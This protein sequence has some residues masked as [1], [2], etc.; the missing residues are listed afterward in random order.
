MA[1]RLET[2][3][4]DVDYLEA[5]GFKGAERFSAKLRREVLEAFVR[6]LDTDEV[7]KSLVP[8][9]AE[10]LKQVMLVSH[11]AGRRR[12]YMD[13]GL[14]NLTMYPQYEETLAWAKKRARLTPEQL[15]AIEH[16]YTE[17]AA[18]I[19]VGFDASVQKRLANAVSKIVDQ[20]QHIQEGVSTLQR[21]F[22]NAGVGK[23]N[24]SLVKALVRTQTNMAYN[25]GRWQ[26]NQDP[27][28]DEIL[29]G[30]EY[31]TINDDRV[32]PNHATEHGVKRP[33]DD[34]Y[35]NTYWPPNGI[36]CRCTTLEVFHTDKP[37][38]TPLT[39]IKDID[40]VSVL[41]L[42]DEGWGFNAGQ[43]LHPL[44]PAPTGPGK[45]K[46]PRS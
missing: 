1:T 35:W 43:M 14:T 20:G 9:L 38:A 46:G 32:R 40:G 45:P 17:K 12:I 25:A 44:P 28:I 10:L 36:N 16:Y 27:A 13:A 41:R 21:G 22:Q 3:I 6:G 2:R 39:D 31:V 30:Y 33:K 8:E 37:K 15:T 42:P 34:P 4:K 7:L 23:Q 26:A 29:W 24:N 19:A 18:N 5:L 11:L